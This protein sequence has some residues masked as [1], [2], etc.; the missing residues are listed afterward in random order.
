M[1]DTKQIEAGDQPFTTTDR[2][3]ALALLTAGC[4][5]AEAKDGGPVQMHFTPE[6][7]RNRW[8]TIRQPNGQKIHVTLLQ[9]ITDSHPG[10]EPE[11]FEKAVMRAVRL[12]IPGINT[13]Y[14]KRDSVFRE[15]MAMHDRLAKEANDAVQEKRAM[16]L[17][18]FGTL[19]EAEAVML[20]CYAYRLNEKDADTYQWLRSP[21]LA[22]GDVKKVVTP[23][24]GVPSEVLEQMSFTATGGG[25]IWSLNLS[26]E[27]RAK[28][29]SDG[30]PFL[31][32]KPVLP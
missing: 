21:N 6:V 10:D 16:V 1:S 25:K 27:N 31:H 12:K 7:C 24:P 26:N 8:I 28:V 4:D 13:Y 17:P 15:A 19:K 14:I 22:M 9:Q 3:L 29:G 5:W 30:K 11:E 2:K 32:P 23:K 18:A 20:I